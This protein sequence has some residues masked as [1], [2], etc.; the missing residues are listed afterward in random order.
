MKIESLENLLSRARSHPLRTSLLVAAAIVLLGLGLFATGFLGEIGRKFA[1]SDT[2]D[3]TPLISPNQGDPGSEHSATAT[4]DDSLR[5]LAQE[6]EEAQIAENAE[7]FASISMP[8]FFDKWYRELTTSLQRTEFE[9]QLRGKTVIWTGTVKSVTPNSDAIR[10]LAEPEDAYGS[11]FLDFKQD[12]RA[13]LLLLNEGDT[14]RFTGT[15]RDFV[16][17]PFLSDCTLLRV[18]E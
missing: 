6:R 14:I 15:I 18:V 9:N 12:Q 4:N 7:S 8:G 16:A 11:A 3:G 10:V 2:P 13:E 1:S 17:S 5:Q